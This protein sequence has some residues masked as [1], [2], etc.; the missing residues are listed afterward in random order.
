MR[1]SILIASLALLSAV[2]PSYAT[3][4]ARP[5][6]TVIV[7]APVI[8]GADSRSRAEL[9]RLEAAFRKDAREA[10][11][12]TPIETIPEEHRWL[13]ENRRAL[14]RNPTRGTMVSFFAQGFLLYDLFDHLPGIRVLLDL[15]G[16]RG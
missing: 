5:G 4:Q 8:E 14:W 10:M 6:P 1:H 2:F 12:A 15:Q 7:L 11:A 9:K 13:E 16:R 3:A